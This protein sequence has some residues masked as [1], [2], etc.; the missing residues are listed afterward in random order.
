MKPL[1]NDIIHV[2]DSGK[3]Q[4]ET[5]TITDASGKDVT[6]Q[7]AITLRDGALSVT[8]KPIQIITDSEERTYNGQAL[9]AGGRVEGLVDG[10][11]VAFTVTGTQTNAGV[12]DNTYTLAWTGTALESDY[13]IS[14][15]RVGTLTVLKRNVT[16]TSATDSKQ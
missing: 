2:G 16:L 1:E 14:S 7:F 13:Q 12:S 6:K 15:T 10:E 11:T 4:I 9:T 3:N 5:V 8:P